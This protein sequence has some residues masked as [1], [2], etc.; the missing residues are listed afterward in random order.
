LIPD[1][2]QLRNVLIRHRLWRPLR[3]VRQAYKARHGGLPRWSALVR[4]QQKW[5]DVLARSRGGPR[6]LIAT[7]VGANH[8]AA[9]IESLLGV[10]LTLR[11]A[12]VEVLL[13]DRALPACML[14]QID[15]YPDR[16]RFLHHGPGKDLCRIC[17]APAR[18]ML[19]QLGIPLRRYGEFLSQ[20]DI[21]EAEAFAAGVPLGEISMLER[22]GVAVGEHAYSG[23]LRFFARGS[24]GAEPGG[25]IVLRRY[26]AASLLTLSVTDRLLQEGRYDVVVLHHGIYVPQGIIAEAARRKGVRVVTWNPAYRKGCFIFTHGE[27]YH[28]ALMKEPTTA[29]EDMRWSNDIE[30]QLL[31]YLESRRVGSEDWISFQHKSVEQTAGL[32]QRTGIDFSRPTIGL[33]T[34]VVWDAQLHYPTNAFGSMLDWLFKTVAWFA[35]RPDLQLVIRVHPAEI[36]GALP[37]RQ[38]VADAIAEAFPELPAN[39]YLVPPESPVSTYSLMEKCNAAIIYGTKTGVELTASGIPVIVAGEAWIRNK[40]LTYDASSEEEYFGIL[41]ALPFADRLS[42]TLI[43]RARKYAFHF[44]FRRMIPLGPLNAVAGWPPFEVAV[45]DIDDL[46]PGRHR[47]LDV[48]CNGVLHGTPFVYEAEAEPAIVG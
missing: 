1:L 19:E 27:T 40:G 28:H 38:K 7:S 36:R 4:D 11:G 26:L 41:E 39:V 31:E 2:A 14:C 10:A 37:S 22:D 21:H 16:G 33:L 24:L 3:L 43:E 23:A 29:W 34:N 8:A 35:S 6:V 13:C 20:P 44:F 45:G 30:R 12:S 5:R 32:E 17:Y 42:G 25:D 48:V 46:A 15:W 47:G 9:T 18:R